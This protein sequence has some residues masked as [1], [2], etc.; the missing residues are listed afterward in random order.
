[1]SLLAIAVYQ[2]TK[3]LAD[4]PLSRAGSLLQGY[5]GALTIS[6]R[7]RWLRPA[8]RG[9]WRRYRRRSPGPS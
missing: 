1:M 5:C 6:R 4:T 9:G 2:S 8:A 7:W 3:M